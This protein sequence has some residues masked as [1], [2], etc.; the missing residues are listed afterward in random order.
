MGRHMTKFWVGV[1]GFSYP[2]WKGTFY[3]DSTKTED[4][5]RVYSERLNSVEINSTFYAMP[6]SKIASQWRES[7]DPGFLFSFKMNRRI[8]HIKKLRDTAA[9]TSSFLSAVRPLSGKLG[10][11][12]VQLPPYVRLDM[13]LLEKFLTEQDQS[14]RYAYE[15]RHSSWFKDEVYKLLARYNC[16][17]CVADTEDMAPEFQKTA[18][19]T[20]VRLRQNRY[21]DRQLEDYSRKIRLFSSS[22]DDCFVYFKHDETGEAARMAV[23]FQK[24]L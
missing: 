24:L 12:L 11:L 8:T 16:A 1:S 5:L 19:F 3:P 7:T 15:F 4:M 21:S 18:S 22:S 10:C 2:K 17:L 23:D 9:E 14:A 20:Y 6:T 13:A